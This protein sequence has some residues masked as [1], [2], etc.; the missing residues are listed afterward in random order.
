[1]SEHPSFKGFRVL[2]VEDNFLVAMSIKSM[3]ERFGCS[4]IGPI[5]GLSEGLEMALREEIGGAVLDIN[6]AGGDSGAIAEALRERNLPFFFITGL[7]SPGSL[8]PAFK[9]VTKLDKPIDEQIL[10]ET[11]M[12]EF[13]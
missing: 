5:A 9:S 13:V 11:M 4:V 8:S 3:L 12:I 2:L 7:A 6:I 1:M 10:E